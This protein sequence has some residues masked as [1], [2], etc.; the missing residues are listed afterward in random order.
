MRYEWK[1][2]VSSD[3]TQ[4]RAYLDDTAAQQII[5]LT[6]WAS[7]GGESSATWTPDPPTY[8]S[9]VLSQATTNYQLL[10]QPISYA[11]ASASPWTNYLL[12]AG[13]AWLAYS[14]LK[15]GKLF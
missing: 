2:Q 13:A 10:A 8:S 14:M 1:K 5:A 3:N 4:I 11:A 9:D 6:P 7:L 12:I 15:K